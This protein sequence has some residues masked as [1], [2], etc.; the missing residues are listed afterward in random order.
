MIFRGLL[1]PLFLK[2]LD[3]MLSSMMP[4]LLIRVAGTAV[5]LLALSACG[6]VTST[7]FT[8]CPASFTTSPTVAADSSLDPA[9]VELAQSFEVSSAIKSTTAQVKLLAVGS[10]T[11]DLILKIETDSSGSPSGITLAT[12]TID[13]TTVSKT[14]A[15]FVT[16]TFSSASAPNLNVDTTYWLRLKLPTATSSNT[17]QWIGNGE[18]AYSDGSAKV[19]TDGTTWSSGLVGSGRDFLFKVGC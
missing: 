12:A 10:P 8:T 16:F 6:D 1:C 9:S 11:G 7:P 18:N 13:A 5:S 4:R 15:G 3:G 2:G 14:A 19:A 17:I